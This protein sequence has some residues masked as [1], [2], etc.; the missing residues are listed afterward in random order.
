MNT[1]STLAR[2]NAWV[3]RRLYEAVA[4]LPEADYLRDRKLFFG[5]IH[6]T[7]DH[8]L[9]IDRMWSGRMTG[10]DRGIRSLDQSL[11]GDFASLRAARVAED[12]RLVTLVDTLSDD[13]ERPITYRPMTAAKDA[14]MQVGQML[15]AL[16]NHQTHHR[17]QVTAALSQDGVSY[18]DLDVPYFVVEQK[19]AG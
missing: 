1:F 3:N 19:A 10:E 8:I 4:T 12:A 15:M 18:R 9:V 14:T 6:R 11:H 13:L 2:F 7:L 5:S 17:G 16:F